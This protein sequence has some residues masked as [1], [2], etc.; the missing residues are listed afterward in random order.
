MMNLSL[1]EMLYKKKAID[2][3]SMTFE[4]FKESL[5]KECEANFTPIH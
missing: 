2:S 4:E 1:S 3:V 5:W